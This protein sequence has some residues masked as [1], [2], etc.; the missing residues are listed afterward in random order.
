VDFCI[1]IGDFANRAAD[2]IAVINIRSD[3]FI[4]LIIMLVMH[5]KWWVDSKTKGMNLFLCAKKRQ[6]SKLTWRF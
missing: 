2:P 5:E 6:V 4:W 3:H 1:G